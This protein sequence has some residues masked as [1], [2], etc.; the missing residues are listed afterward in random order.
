LKII[1]K[2]IDG[3]ILTSREVIGESIQVGERVLTPI[4]EIKTYCKQLTIKNNSED[5]IL[6]GF[7]VTPTSLKITEGK[8]KW[9]LQIQDI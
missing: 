4:I 1:E 2:L 5:P 7:I 3:V 6:I 8:Q 9:T